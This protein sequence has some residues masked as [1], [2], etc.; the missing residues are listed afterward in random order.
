M[1]SPM[2]QTKTVTKSLLEEEFSDESSSDEDYK[3]NEDEVINT[4]K[5]FFSLYLYIF[6]EIIT[7]I[8]CKCW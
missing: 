3:P 1:S 7:Q 6:L 2:K 8:K 4:L 5:F